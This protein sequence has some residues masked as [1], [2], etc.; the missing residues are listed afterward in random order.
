MLLVNTWQGG[1]TDYGG[2]VGRHEAFDTGGGSADVAN[3]GDH[4]MILATAATDPKVAILYVPGVS[5]GAIVAYQVAGDPTAA[6]GGTVYPDK[7]LG[8]FGGVNTSTAM[9]AVKD[10]LTNTIM[11]GEMQRITTIAATAWNANTGPNFSHDGWAIGGSST[12]FTTGLAVTNNGGTA[13]F[14]TFP[15]PMMNNGW[16]ACPGSDHPGGGNFGLGDASVRF[17]TTNIDPNIF[18][19]MGAVADRV[20]ITVP[21]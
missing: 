4:K 20:P 16:W 9:A 11:T 18:C 13:A 14:G 10:G 2:C 19:L 3:T 21:E 17:F 8:I 15:A 12:L 6:A 1:G 5:G 7:A